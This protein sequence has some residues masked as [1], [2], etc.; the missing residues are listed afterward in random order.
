MQPPHRQTENQIPHTE[1]THRTD[2]NSKNQITQTGQTNM[3][4]C[5]QHECTIL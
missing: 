1:E 5:Q 4:S 2:V 3:T